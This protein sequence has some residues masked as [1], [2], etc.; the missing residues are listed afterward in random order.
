MIVIGRAKKLGDHSQ[1]RFEIV[2]SAVGNIL[3][4]LFVPFV[5]IFTSSVGL[6]NGI[7]TRQ[8]LRYSL[9][10]LAFVLSLTSMLLLPTVWYNLTHTEP[11]EATHVSSDAAVILSPDYVGQV[12][13]QPTS[14]PASF[15]EAEGVTDASVDEVKSLISKNLELSK[16]FF[17]DKDFKIVVTKSDGT[18]DS[19]YI[20]LKEN[21]ESL[22]LLDYVGKTNTL[23]KASKFDM[24]SEAVLAGSFSEASVT[25]TASKTD[26]TLNDV[27]LAVQ[28]EQVS[29][30]LI[31]ATGESV[32]FAVQK[33]DKII[34]NQKGDIITMYEFVSL[35]DEDY[36]QYRE[37]VKV[38]ASESSK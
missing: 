4:A 14:S 5:S 30:G 26:K 15:G 25:T 21:P 16:A 35:D 23:L 18:V 36:K 34:L 11:K 8:P 37:V 38:Q 6:K 22:V 28:G 13:G 32:N 27:L 7:K 12:V 20:F 3:L 10:G 31:Y 1:T 29:Y 2:L 17:K 9:Q 33:L 19:R 24:F